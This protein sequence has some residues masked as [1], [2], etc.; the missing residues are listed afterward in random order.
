M[1]TETHKQR[2]QKE[3][4]NEVFSHAMELACGSA[5]PTAMHAAIELGVFDILANAGPGATLSAMLECIYGLLVHHCVLG[6]SVGDNDD[7]DGHPFHRSYCLVLVS[8]HFVRNQ[9][10]VSLAPLMAL[11]HD[12][13]SSFHDMLIMNKIYVIIDVLIEAHLAF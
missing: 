6:C 12:Q 13:L 8:K 11:I 10:G 2:E 4:E 3:E 1:E 7:S 5:L 9:D